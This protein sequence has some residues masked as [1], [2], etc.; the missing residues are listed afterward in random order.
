M[1]KVGLR[2]Q[3]WRTGMFLSNSRFVPTITSNLQEMP[4]LLGL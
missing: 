3:L 1:Q 4:Q 2:V